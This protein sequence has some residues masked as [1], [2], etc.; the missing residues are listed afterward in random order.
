MRASELTK[1]SNRNYNYI[2]ALNII[3]SELIH[4]GEIICKNMIFKGSIGQ[5][6]L[7]IKLD[8]IYYTLC[9]LKGDECVSITWG[10]RV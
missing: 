3:A 7:V 10:G 8:D 2:K 9:M 6:E 5:Y 1:L 4:D